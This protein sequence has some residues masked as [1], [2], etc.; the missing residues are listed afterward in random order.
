MVLPH[1]ASNQA[2][3]QTADRRENLFSMTSTLKAEAQLAL[4]SGHSALSR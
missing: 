3:E 1:N 2:L 4:V